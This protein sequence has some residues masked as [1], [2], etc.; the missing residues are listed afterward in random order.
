M[1]ID[2]S[3]EIKADYLYVLVTGIYDLDQAIDLLEEVLE[4]SIQHKQPRI[5]IDYR[6]LQRI[7][8]LLTET[9]IFSA[10]VA[11]L[12]QHHTAIAG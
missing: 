5:L 6:Q 4:A 12:V 8:P 3:I 11:R 9:Y 2:I 7:F 1:S 10:S